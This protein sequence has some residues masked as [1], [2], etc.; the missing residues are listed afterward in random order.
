MIKPRKII[1]E[2]QAYPAPAEGRY[3][4]IRL[5]FNENTQGFPQFYPEGIS[6]TAIST[7]PEYATFLKKAATTFGVTEDSMV[8]TNGSDEALLLVAL[9]F[10]EQGD[11]AVLSK[12]CFAVMPQC[13]KLAG[14]Q[15][16]QVPVREDLGFDLDGLEAELPGA[17]IA[18][19]AS[20][21]NPTGAVIPSAVIEKWC[22]KFSETLFVIDEAYGEY[23][24]QTVLPL[25][26]KF[27]NLLVMKTFSKAWGM[28]GLR[29]G[30]LFG[31]SRLIDFINRIRLPY[32][33]NSAA[34]ATASKLLENQQT[35]LD[36]AKATMQ[37]K[38]VIEQV[39]RDRG[40]RVLSGQA[41]S[42]L[43]KLDP[44]ACKAFERFARSQ[45]VLVRP[46]EETYIRVSV[47]T[48]PEMEKFLEVLTQF[49]KTLVLQK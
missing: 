3:G 38:Q 32:S 24:G 7:Y 12:P 10:V 41:N 6:P 44:V 9:T 25:I 13:L 40:F 17:K 48:D 28:A 49:E 4:A 19:F 20:P 39:L 2:L 33:V 46:R 5:D 29:L 1:D 42:F 35:V 16:K 45:A 23:Y 43:L 26:G 36:A 37:R 34:V 31:Q 14:A 27:P 8:A 18:M 11:R 30:L 22:A 15:L 47:G 21:E